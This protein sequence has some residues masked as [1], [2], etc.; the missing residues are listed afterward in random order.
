MGFPTTVVTTNRGTLPTAITVGASPY[1]YQNTSTAEETI[2]IDTNATLIEF[3]RDNSTFYTIASAPVEK[4]LITLSIFDR[5]RVTYTT[6]P[7][8]VKIPR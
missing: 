1:V 8:M 3:T 4:T 6:T 2:L 7:V 5:V